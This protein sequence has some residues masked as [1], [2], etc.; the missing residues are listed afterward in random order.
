[1]GARLVSLA[2]GPNWSE[3]SPRARL[4][5]VIM[6]QQSRDRDSDEGPAATFWG[7]HKAIAMAL[8]GAYE[9]WQI[10]EIRRDVAALVSLGAVQVENSARGRGQAI[11]RVTPDNWPAATEEDPARA[12]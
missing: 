11:Y 3:L 10:R 7:G 12:R 1:M 8:Y 5:L 4:V 9:A 2:L 6:C